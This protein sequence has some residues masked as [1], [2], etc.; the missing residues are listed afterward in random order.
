MSTTSTATVRLNNI[1]AI[2]VD[3]VIVD[4]YGDPTDWDPIAIPAG[5]FQDVPGLKVLAGT[6]SI[7]WTATAIGRKDNGPNTVKGLVD[8]DVV[9]VK[10]GP[11]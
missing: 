5:K 7:D 1:D 2:A 10:A 11:P 9:D 3:V 8:K 6:A 4:N